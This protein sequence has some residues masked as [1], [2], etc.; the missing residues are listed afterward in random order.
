MTEMTTKPA[1]M[2]TVGANATT[3]TAAAR[4]NAAVLSSDFETFLTMLTAQM[5][6]QDPLNPLDASDYATQL[7]TFS[8][9]EQQVLTNDLLTNLGAQL[10][11][12]AFQQMAAWVGM[13]ALARA[14]VRYEG[15]PIELRPEGANGAESARLVIY[16]SSGDVVATHQLDLSDPF[17]TWD[18]KDGGG[19]DV[20]NGVYSFEIESYA[21]GELINTHTALAY[22]EIGEVR[23]EAGYVYLTLSDGS[24]VQADTVIGLRSPDGAS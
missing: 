1:S 12:S 19:G 3:N 11:G 6:N 15:Q 9:V 23:E 18:G 7:A 17:F 8:Q 10:A 21:E 20:P 4:S 16:D 5:Q 2:A 22:S 13:E 24:L 14:P